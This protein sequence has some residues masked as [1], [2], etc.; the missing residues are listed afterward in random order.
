MCWVRKWNK[1]RNSHIALL[2]VEIGIGTLDKANGHYLLK[3]N[4]CISYDPVILPLSTSPRE[5]LTY[6]NLDTYTRMLLAVFSAVRNWCFGNNSA[7][8]NRMNGFQYVPPMKYYT[9]IKMNKQKLYMKGC[10]ALKDKILSKRKNND[11][12]IYESIFM[13]FKNEQQ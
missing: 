5:I 7:Q 6:L 3:R 11:K 1:F 9:T 13:K 4:M 12:V 2:E 8:Q 10:L